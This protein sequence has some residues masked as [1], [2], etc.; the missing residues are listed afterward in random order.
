MNPFEDLIRDLSLHMD[1]DLHPDSR[2]S[3]LIMFAQDEL[4]VQIDLDSNADKIIVG[5]QLGRITPGIY[6]QRIFVQAMRTNGTAQT[7]RGVLAFSE[8]NDTLVLFQF[9]NLFTLNGEK[10]NR[11]LLLFKEHAKIWKTALAS[12]DIPQL[13]LEE[14]TA[15]PGMFGLKR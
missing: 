10:L 15:G 14:G 13:G 2:Q 7:Q 4:L 12:G 9:L 11:F 8:K 6:R 3:C 1:V 5:S